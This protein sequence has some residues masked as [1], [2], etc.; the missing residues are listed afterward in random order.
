[1]IPASVRQGGPEFVI[2][3]N[4]L[5]RAIGRP[6]PKTCKVYREISPKWVDVSI[7]SFDYVSDNN[8]LTA[9]IK[10]FKKNDYTVRIVEDSDK[11]STFNEGSHAIYISVGWCS[12]PN[13]K[14]HSHLSTS[15]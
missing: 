1:M 11:R 14:H 8:G 5:I 3:Y 13:H 10:H 15:K 6:S 4:K 9:V 2:L 12:N 7:L